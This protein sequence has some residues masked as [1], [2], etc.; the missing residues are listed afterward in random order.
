MKNSPHRWN[1][2]VKKSIR[3]AR[4]IDLSSKN[5]REESKNAPS[6]LPNHLRPLNQERCR[7]VLNL[8]KR[9]LEREVRIHKPHHSKRSAMGDVENQKTPHVSY[10]H[11]SKKTMKGWNKA[12]LQKSDQVAKKVIRFYSPSE[13][14]AA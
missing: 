12:N 13:R 7:Q 4:Q 5:N 6:A 3:K 14:K 10:S 8:F 2:E 9:H 11:I 1:H